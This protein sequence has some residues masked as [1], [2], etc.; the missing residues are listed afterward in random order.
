[1]I[2]IHVVQAVKR[3]FAD[4]EEVIPFPVKFERASVILKIQNGGD[5][6]PKGLDLDGWNIT[7]SA[8]TEVREYMYCCQSAN[9]WNLHIQPAVREYMYLHGPNLYCSYSSVC[10]ALIKDSPQITKECVNKYSGGEIK[11][12]CQFEVKWTG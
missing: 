7:S 6:Y 11:P 8:P 9:V 4:F 5:I 2:L 3:E 10:T 1:M 12:C